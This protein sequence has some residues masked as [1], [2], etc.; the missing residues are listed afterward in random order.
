MKDVLRLSLPLTLWLI[1]FS[2]L[3]GLQGLVCAAEWYVLPGPG[4]MAWGRVVVLA[5]VAAAVLLQAG[6][7]LLVGARQA[8][9]EMDF[10]RGATL[11]LAVVALLATV[12]TSVPIVVL[13]LC[14]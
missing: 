14:E 11:G 10:M 2:A 9:A 7:L 12:W 8:S 13:P 6:V 1:S 5:A 4:G 3:Y